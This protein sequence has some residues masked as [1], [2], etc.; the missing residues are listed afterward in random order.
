MAIKSTDQIKEFA[1]YLK[2][3]NKIVFFGGAGVSTDSGL[4]DY[5]SKDGRY[6]AM[7]NDGK[8]PKKVMNIKYILDHPKQFFKRRNNAK[9]IKPNLSHYSLVE[10][11]KMG[12]EVHVVTQNVDSLHQKAGSTS[13]FELHGNS[14]TWYCMSCGN[15]EEQDDVIWEDDLPTCQIDG[16]LM[17][18]SVVYFGEKLDWDLV[19]KARELIAEADLLIIAGT[20]L[21]VSPAK[22]LVQAF[23]GNHAVIINK[24]PLNTK[25]L[26][27]DLTFVAPISET[28]SAAVELLEKEQNING[29][30][31]ND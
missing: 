11:E 16:G 2:K 15:V 9:E 4:P 12:K 3:A 31:R 27:I 8:D 29:T 20:S 13:V 5:R 7:E 24:D 6:T 17:R 1:R 19:E 23:N 30:S 14:R 10:L 26:P 25:K 18:P 22:R 28:M 21:T